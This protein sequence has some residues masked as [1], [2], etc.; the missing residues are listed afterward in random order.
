MNLGSFRALVALL[1]CTLTLFAASGSALASNAFYFQNDSGQPF[2]TT[3]TPLPKC[4]YGPTGI[5][6]PSDK[7]TREGGSVRSNISFPT[8]CKESYGSWLAYNQHYLGYSERS[9]THLWSGGVGAVAFSPYNPMIGSASLSCRSNG[10]RWERANFY[11]PISPYMT[12]AVDGLRCTVDWRPG[13][14]SPAARRALAVFPAL[15]ERQAEV[16]HLRLVNSL[17]PVRDGAAQVEVETFG[18]DE[19]VRAEVILRDRAGNFLGRG[20]APARL[21]DGPTDVPVP[22]DPETL[23]RF[24]EDRELYVTAVVDQAGEAAGSGDSTS[25]LLLRRGG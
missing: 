24:G 16:S 5:F 19:S 15:A 18:L 14:K 25:R 6:I 23:E 11:D 22:L 12:I 2:S 7:P 3:V 1:A 13:M 17:A 20:S 4:W 10:E 21:D 8:A 9:G